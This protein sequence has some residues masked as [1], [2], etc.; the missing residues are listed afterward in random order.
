L[1]EKWNPK[2]TV[3]VAQKKQTKDIATT[4]LESLKLKKSPK[5]GES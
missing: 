4:N 1:D 5:K 3:I 2:S